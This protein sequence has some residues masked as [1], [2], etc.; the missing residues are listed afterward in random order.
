MTWPDNYSRNANTISSNIDKT[1]S[2]LRITILYGMEHKTPHKHR[3][4][5]L[6]NK[7]CADKN[8]EVMRTNY[9]MALR[10]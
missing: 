8:P 4:Q 7:E 6:H 3:S 5:C 1:R 9:F 2:R 10:A